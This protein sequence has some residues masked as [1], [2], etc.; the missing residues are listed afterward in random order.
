MEKKIYHVRSTSRPCLPNTILLQSSIPW[1]IA[2]KCIFPSK[3]KKSTQ[4]KSSFQALPLLNWCIRWAMDI[5]AQFYDWMDRNRFRH[6]QKK[7]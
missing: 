5:T 4:F 1:I 3:E 2:R 7:N 6:L